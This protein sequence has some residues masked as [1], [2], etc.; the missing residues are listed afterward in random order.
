MNEK[1]K[2]YIVF[3]VIVALVL[4]VVGYNIELSNKSKKVYE[5]FTT[6]FTSEDEKIIFIGREGCSWCQLFR[7]IFDYYS[8]KYEISYAQ[9]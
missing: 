8:K 3:A 7:P 9:A 2:I 4:V 5:E 6:N 1:S